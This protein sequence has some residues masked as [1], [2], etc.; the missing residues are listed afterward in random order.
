MK[1]MNCVQ[2]LGGQPEGKRPL[3]E[4]GVEGSLEWVL[5]EVGWG[6]GLD[7]TGVGQGPVAGCC[8]YGNGHLRFIKQGGLLTS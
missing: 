8:E 1:H 5:R 4:L 7:S 6:D 3:K 2:G